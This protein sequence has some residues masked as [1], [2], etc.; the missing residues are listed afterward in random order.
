MQ[1]LGQRAVAHRHHHLDHARY[2]GSRLCMTDIGLDRAEPQRLLTGTTLPVCRK[3]SLGLNRV[4]QSGAGSV[5]LHDIDL[6]ARQMGACECLF[7][8][9]FL[10]RAVRCRQS[11]ACPVLIDS[12][13]SYETKH[14]M[15]QAL[16]IRQALQQQHAHALRPDGAIGCIRV[17]LCSCVAR[18]SALAR[19]LDVG[20]WG[21]QQRDA[22]GKRESTFT[23]AQRRAGQ[24]QRHKRGGAGGVDRHR[25]ALEAKQIR[26]APR[27]D[28]ARTA[29]PQVGFHIGGHRI[30]PVHATTVIVV[31]HSGE[32]AGPTTGQRL[33]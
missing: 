18:E 8:H 31:N 21:S 17:G 24:V 32:H 9:A 28:A 22:A 4:S 20:L 1:G 15:A 2:A 27:R 25:R 12:A 33:G 5:S 23:S 14:R 11:I 10:G 19:E 6:T 13:A 7:D 26:H 29:E 30:R 16:S 3:Q